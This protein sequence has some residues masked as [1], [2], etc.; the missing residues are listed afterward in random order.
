MNLSAIEIKTWTYKDVLRNYWRVQAT[1]RGQSEL[2]SSG[3]YETSWDTTIE[4]GDDDI[5]WEPVYRGFVNTEYGHLITLNDVIQDWLQNT[6]L[7]ALGLTEHGK[8]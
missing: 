4:N 6:I 5:C 8:E 3:Y 7:V 2:D 1:R